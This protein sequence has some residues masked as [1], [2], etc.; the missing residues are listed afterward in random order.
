MFVKITI[1]QPIAIVLLG[2]NIKHAGSSGS[3]ITPVPLTNAS[4]D[5]LHQSIQVDSTPHPTDPITPSKHSKASHSSALKR[6]KTAEP[7][8]NPARTQIVTVPSGAIAAT[9]TVLSPGRPGTTVL[10]PPPKRLEKPIGQTPKP[11]PTPRRT[12][13]KQII[14]QTPAPPTPT[15]PPKTTV[16][17]TTTP[18]AHT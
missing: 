1:E 11:P 3:C 15:P 14:I 6:M 17:K 5:K 12:P 18:K 10:V 9:T 16:T 7:I 8:N 2:Y 4:K 13:P